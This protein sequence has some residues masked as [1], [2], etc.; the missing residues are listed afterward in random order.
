MK[1][2]QVEAKVCELSFYE[3]V[4][5]FWSTIIKEQPIYNWHIEYLCDE[6]Q[7]IAK[8]VKQRLPCEY[9]TIVN[10]PPNSTKSTIC[11]QMFPVWCWV[12]DPTIKII[13]GSYSMSLATRDAVLSRDIIRS[14]KFIELFPII[15]I[16]QDT[17][18]K[19]DYQNN[20]TGARTATS[21]GGSIIGRHAH[22]IIIDDPLN[23][24]NVPSDAELN[25]ANSWVDYVSTTRKTDSKVSA[26]VLVMQRLNEKDPSGHLLQMKGRDIHH[27][28]LP[29]IITDDVK[30]ANLKEKYV[31]GLLDPVRIDHKDL[32]KKKI[33][34]GSYAYAGQFLQSPA[35][36]DGGIIKKEWFQK[37]NMIELTA[38][39]KKT[40]QELTWDFTIDGA[41]TKDKSNAQS[42]I[43]AYCY[44]EN[45]LY[46]RDVLGVW[47]ETPEFIKTLIE[48]VSRNGYSNE[49]T[50]RVEPKATGLPVAQII[51]AETNLNIV[52]DKSPT[53]DKVVRVRSVTPFME[54]LRVHLLSNAGWVDDFTHQCITFPNG[55]LKD[56]V[57]CLTMAISNITQTQGKVLEYGFM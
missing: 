53:A 33:G 56:K 14:E 38:K 17:D 25:N 54:S 48:F 40:N 45:N 6:L 35:P 44:F 8:R 16:K 52:F 34:L 47:E 23:P 13:T 57:D 4:K 36:S 41:F 9:D 26:F 22:L 29:A 1:K 55:R 49:S 2:Q 32:E 3:F 15:S 11:S 10:I 46:I 51:K 42:A 37:F 31:N 18:N 7:K 30:P 20:Q 28:C 12:L 19:T 5:I 43:L 21:V 27:I 39:A 50:I 24:N